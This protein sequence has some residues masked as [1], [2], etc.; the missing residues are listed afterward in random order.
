MSAATFALPSRGLR[1]GVH[2]DSVTLILMLSI[3]L[4]GLVM[5]TSASISIA[6]REGGFPLAYLERQFI[7]TLTGLSL[8]AVLFCIKPE[9]LERNSTVLLALAARCSSSC[10]FRA[11][12]TS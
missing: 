9:M 2:I 1:G 12:A 4:L 6:S 11:S 10:S 5:V 3:V 7:L 8:G